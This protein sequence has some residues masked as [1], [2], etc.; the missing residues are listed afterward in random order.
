[1]TNKKFGHKLTGLTQSMT[2]LGSIMAKWAI[3]LMTKLWYMAI[4]WS[5]QFMTKLW[6]M[7]ENIT[8]DPQLE[9]NSIALRP[10]FRNLLRFHPTSN[11]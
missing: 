6:Y 9:S 1:M 5:D 11:M 7:A 8:V 2:K 10:S 3:R 4:I